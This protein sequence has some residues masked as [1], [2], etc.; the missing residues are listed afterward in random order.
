MG[1]REAIHNIFVMTSKAVRRFGL[2]DENIYPALCEG[3]EGERGGRHACSDAVA[4]GWGRCASTSC[5]D[6]RLLPSCSLL[7]TWPHTLTGWH[8]LLPL[9]L[10]VASPPAFDRPGHD[11]SW[12]D[13]ESPTEGTP[14][15]GRSCCARQTDG[16]QLLAGCLAA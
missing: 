1:E 9:L 8:P 3:E 12:Q 2:W 10:S 4:C 6:C 11:A 5:T 16:Y 14:V 13:D 15:A 7:A